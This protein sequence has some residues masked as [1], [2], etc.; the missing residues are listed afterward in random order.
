MRR[1]VEAPHDAPVDD[2]DAPVVQQHHVPR[3]HVAVEGAPAHRG[4]EER[5]HDLLDQRAGIEAEV[6]HLAR[7]SM[8]TPSKYSMVSTLRPESSGYGSGTAMSLRSNSLCSRRKW[9]SAARLVAQV[10]LLA[11]LHPE[12]VEQLQGGAGH[13]IPGLAHQDLE[14]RLHEVEVGRHRVLDLGPQHLDGHLAPVVEPG[15]VHH[16]MDAVPIGTGSNSANRV[17]QRHPEVLLHP[18]ADVGERHGRSGVEAGPEL[19]GHV[20]AEHAGD[21][22]PKRI[23]GMI[24]PEKIIF[25]R[26]SNERVQTARAPGL[27]YG[28]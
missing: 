5:A 16:R 2:A 7:S 19:V 4:E 27:C 12:P 26:S 22:K 25:A 8:G 11:D 3:V 1:G 28:F 23:L 10:H 9:A 17:A 15:P 14:E 13:L 18:L 20:V 24:L 21:T 6:G